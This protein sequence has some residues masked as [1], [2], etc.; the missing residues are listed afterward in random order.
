MPVSRAKD[1]NSPVAQTLESSVPEVG[2]LACSRRDADVLRRNNGLFSFM[3]AS[4]A[5]NQISRADLL[6]C[7][8]A[9]GPEKL[10]ALALA[11][12]FESR[13]AA[14]VNIVKLHAELPALEAVIAIAEKS[15]VSAPQAQYL[16]VVS[17]RYLNPDD[18]PSEAPAWFREAKAYTP[19]AP[20][21]YAPENARPPAQPPLL[22]WSRLWPFL[23]RALGAQRLGHKPDIPRLVERVACGQTLAR[24][25]R[26]SRQTW[27]GE[28]RL[29]FDFAPALTPFWADFHDLR[30]RLQS[31]RGRAGLSLIAFP[32]GDPGGR[33]WIDGPDGWREAERCPALAPDAPLLILSDLG[34]HDAANLRRRRWLSFGARLK[35]SGRR[36]VV[37]APCP[38]RR[39]TADLA[40]TFRPVYW[41]RGVPVRS[42]GF[43]RS[44]ASRP[45]K[46]GTTNER[47]PKG[48]TT[49]ERPPKGG[50]ANE[51]P[52]KGGPANERLLDLLS[53]AIRVEPALLRAARLLLPAGEADAGDEADAWNHADVHATPAAFYF[54][55][56]AIARHRARFRDDPLRERAAELIL[57]HHAH[58]SPAIVHEE[59]LI[60]AELTGA[61]APPQAQAFVE[62]LAKT[63]LDGAP[64]LIQEAAAWTRRMGFRQHAGMWSDERLAA[65][66]LSAHLDEWRREGKLALPDGLSLE[67]LGWLLA[68]SAQTRSHVL[69]QRGEWL[70]F[71]A[72]TPP[73][74][75]TGANAPGSPL[76]EIQAAAPWVAI[77]RAGARI[78]QA[79]AAP[80]PLPGAANMRLRTER[81]E[82]EIESML[83]PTWAAAIGRD[84]YGLFA[85]LKLGEARQRFRW[86][87]PGKFLMGSPESEPQRYD[88]EVLHPVTL[89]QGFWLADSACAQALW[90]AVMGENPSGFRDDP[91]SPVENVS[92][93]MAQTF[94]AR[95][96]EE[97]PGLN[98]RLPTEAEW[99]YACRAG[100][101]TPFSF[102]QNVT[103]EQVNYNGNHPYAG[104]AKG[105]YREKTVP[106]K[107]L[108]PNPWGLYEMHGN[109]WEW[110]RDRYGPYGAEAQTDPR[111]PDQGDDRVLRGGSWISL[112]G[113]VRS[114]SRSGLAPGHRYD[115]FGFRLAL[116]PMA[117]GRQAGNE[118]P[119]RPDGQ[120]RGSAS[121]QFGGDGGSAPGRKSDEA[122][123]PSVWK[124]MKNWLKQS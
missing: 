14:P 6:E 36:P 95:L 17:R 38:P 80:I 13:P 61:P 77:E 70:R 23:K 12:G 53:P 51:R 94:L 56:A 93:D 104:G 26:V 47:P 85:D 99:E 34:W 96:N 37:L 72:D 108:P 113:G 52:P 117:T 79:L 82:I 20:E 112:G 2:G 105:L 63:Q 74:L 73:E 123:K 27:A 64:G 106:V 90:T 122:T 110:C 71:D 89:S 124:R 25:P 118:P 22:P 4:S 3:G 75:E 100:T 68:P 11:L 39:W 103:P 115:F 43:S 19:E 28:C 9:Q 24:L 88:D 45:P 40:R 41:D 49:N 116:G 32:D 111:G 67:R 16:R 121:G 97:I 91:Q 21:L 48:G 69:R 114:A 65:L 83:K 107:S 76:A 66:W 84:R 59:S 101:E 62:R 31:L 120:P 81:E 57:R 8:R 92:W 46:G 78:A 55:R 102:G 35:A 58:L 109:V 98:V 29:I 50:P 42:S 10:E 60:L 119:A 54:D 86:I 30:R 33:C 7:L 44:P 15:P 1:G 87:A 18:A 5:M